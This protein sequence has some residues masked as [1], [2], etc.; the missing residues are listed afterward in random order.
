MDAQ[1]DAPTASVK[2]MVDFVDILH[3]GSM[4]TLPEVNGGMKKHK[5]LREDI[6]PA[7]ATNRKVQ[8][9]LNEFMDLLSEY[10]ITET[11]QEQNQLT[12]AIATVPEPGQMDSTIRMTEQMNLA[13][14]ATNLT[15][16]NLPA[17]DEI[18]SAMPTIDQMDC[19]TR[20]T[21]PVGSALQTTDQT[22]YNPL[23]T[24]QVNLEPT[25]K[26][27]LVPPAKECS[28]SIL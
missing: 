9:L 10:E 23:I 7:M 28:A 22:Q 3:P 5:L 27:N 26:L 18:P 16:C 19:T 4:H 1:L 11:N 14:P 25:D 12:P 21:D 6:L 24:D 2:E 8:R 13:P 15:D 17:T 20:A